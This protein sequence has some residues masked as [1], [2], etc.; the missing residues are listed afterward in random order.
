MSLNLIF[1]NGRKRRTGFTLL[2]LIVVIGI[3]GLT[4]TI[5]TTIFYKM[6]TVWND[7][8][9]RA[10]LNAAADNIFRMMNS[11][12]NNVLSAELTGFS[13]Q[14]NTDTESNN[15][16]ISLAVRSVSDVDSRNAWATYSVNAETLERTVQSLSKEKEVAIREEAPPPFN[17]ANVLKMSIDFLSSESG[18][19]WTK[20][21]SGD[22]LPTAVR[23]N[24]CIADDVRT[25]IQVTRKATFPINIR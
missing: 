16:S 7:T 4:T 10:D 13:I 14:S 18:A 20:G 3:M 9:T 15:D 22:E 2:E 1:K 25:N 5:G 21:W 24:L 19:S 23:V 6:T 8:K 17:R 12:F 11:D